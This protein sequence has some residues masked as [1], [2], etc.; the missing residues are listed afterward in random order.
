MAVIVVRFC[1]AVNPI[2]KSDYSVCGA[3]QVWM[4]EDTSIDDGDIDSFSREIFLPL[5][6]CGADGRCRYIERC[7]FYAIQIYAPPE[8]KERLKK[9]NYPFMNESPEKKMEIALR[10]PLTFPQVH[11]LIVGTTNAA[12]FRANA[13]YI[14]KGKLTEIEMR[15]IRDHWNEVCEPAWE[16]LT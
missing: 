12:H 9:L 16:G 10:F 8:Y 7:F 2:L 4:R 11:T 5:Y 1:S 6:C 3:S 15:S 14:A 13:D